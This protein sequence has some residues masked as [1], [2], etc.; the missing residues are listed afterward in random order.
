MDDD[1]Q[2][3][4]IPSFWTRQYAYYLNAHRHPMNR[5][6]HLFGIPII[7]GTLALGLY[8]KNWK[9]VAVGQ[10]V[11]WAFQLAGH[12]IEGN[13]PAFLGNPISFLMGPLMVTVEFLELLGFTIGFA[14]QAREVVHGAP[15]P[16][17]SSDV[18]A[19]KAA[20]K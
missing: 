11:G 3:A 14:E 13:K 7:V 4:A 20:A 12:G 17:S 8:K 1:R 10:L 9:I 6:T 18:E 5:L 19:M 16:S 2:I 15:L